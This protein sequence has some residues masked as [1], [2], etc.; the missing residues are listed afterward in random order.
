MI[1]GGI[2]PLLVEALPP[3]E[4]P[5]R[6]VLAALHALHPI[7]DVR[8]SDVVE[9][10]TQP[11]DAYASLYSH[12]A[13]R[14]FTEILSQ[15]ARTG[16]DWSQVSAVCHI[17]SQTINKER[18]ALLVN[19]GILDRLAE[20]LVALSVQHID[21]SRRGRGVVIA[22]FKEL[23]IYGKF[24]PHIL[25]AISSIVSGS[26]YYVICLLDH[27]IIKEHFWIHL[28]ADPPGK[29]TRTDDASLCSMLKI[30]QLLPEM[31][32][33]SSRSETAGSRA[34]PAL[35]SAQQAPRTSSVMDLL[36]PIE[37]SSSDANDRTFAT[38]AVH[39]DLIQ[40]LICMMRSGDD[41]CMIE[42]ARLITKIT[43]AGFNHKQTYRVLSFFVV[44][45]L[46]NFFSHI[47]RDDKLPEKQFAEFLAKHGSVV[48]KV[49]SVLAELLPCSPSLQKGSAIEHNSVT[50]IGTLLKTTFL[51]LD[52]KP[53]CWS[54]E[55]GQTEPMDLGPSCKLGDPP[56]AKEILQAMRCRASLL[57]LLAAVTDRNDDFRR[58]VVDQGI[59]PLIVNS[60]S[61]VSPDTVTDMAKTGNEPWQGKLDANLGN[62]STVVIAACDVTRNMSRSIALLRTSLIDAAISNPI[63]ILTKNSNLDLVIA[64]T[65][66][67]CNIVTDVSP[68]REVS[69]PY[70]RPN[71]LPRWYQAH[72][73]ALALTQRIVLFLL[74]YARQDLI[75]KGIIEI[76]CDYAKNADDPLR[77]SALWA[78]KHIMFQSPNEVKAKCLDSL[79]MDWL[80]SILTP[81]DLSSFQ[82]AEAAAT[83]GSA[84]QAS[85]PAPSLS[86]GA[87]AA[88]E[89]V[90]ILNAPE[91]DAPMSDDPANAADQ[92]MTDTADEGAE[93]TADDEEEHPLNPPY[94]R[95]RLMTE[96]KSA[97]DRDHARQPHR[98]FLIMQTQAIDILR[99]LI[100][101]AGHFE[102]IDLLLKSVG[103]ARLFSLLNK[104]LKL[105]YH[106]APTG[107]L[108]PAFRDEQCYINLVNSTVFVCVHLA[109]GNMAQRNLLVEQEVLMRAVRA[110]Y[111]HPDAGIRASCVW[112][113]MN[114]IWMDDGG[115]EHVVR[116]RALAL[117][118][119]GFVDGIEKLRGDR[120]L[121]VK[122]RANTAMTTLGQLLGLGE[123]ATGATGNGSGRSR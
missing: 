92:A 104:K 59:L 9:R 58:A 101:G 50:F 19:V 25:E 30:H 36:V 67:V 105:A 114:L 37:S 112:M 41:V 107:S 117:Q 70:P 110:L 61:L 113:T 56:I 87:N 6:V 51:E 40:W 3:T 16:V 106:D 115:Q 55:S 28:S 31:P 99:N 84:G 15:D 32:V 13:L 47:F 20:R 60:L 116:D 83:Q 121:D 65:D 85:T 5:T 49:S 43:A 29:I 95:S 93:E 7:V 111:E 14:A 118:R 78:V 72:L 89:R 97:E 91:E 8:L 39:S 52:I 21:A 22:L 26:Q 88:G 38:R 82:G 63:F 96:I 27:P 122:E 80:L 79:T 45:Q 75:A 24:L 34:F 103:H 1:A 74:T 62:I 73:R 71:S 4:N 35:S 12:T 2:L 109:A 102:M 46:T 10:P 81:D 94:P 123:G 100:Q 68:A 23:G 42:A 76:M 69:F 18:Q 53:A 108:A 86:T 119:M 11:I 66:V 120:T 48:E 17:I 98:D 77:L 90:N 54:P 33:P 44:S 57:S 64:A